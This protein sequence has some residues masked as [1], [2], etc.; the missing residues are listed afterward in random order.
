M[1]L[2]LS[3]PTLPAFQSRLSWNNLQMHFLLNLEEHL[4]LGIIYIPIINSYF[5]TY[6]T[7]SWWN[8]FRYLSNN[9]KHFFDVVT[10]QDLWCPVVDIIPPSEYPIPFETRYSISFLEILIIIFTS[11]VA[12]FPKRESSRYRLC[13]CDLKNMTLAT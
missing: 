6:F 3:F 7:L 13:P 1:R 2:F 12:Y 4:Y 9:A 8:S 5:L 11:F 10:Y